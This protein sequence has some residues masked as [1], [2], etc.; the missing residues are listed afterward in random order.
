MKSKEI[1]V[2]RI[3]EVSDTVIF[4]PFKILMHGIDVE[5]I[6]G[7]VTIHTNKRRFIDKLVI[8][9]SFY[10]SA[11]ATAYRQLILSRQPRPEVRISV[12]RVRGQLVPR[13]LN[14]GWSSLGDP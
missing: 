5:L 14:Q 6:N 3:P 1:T 2:F 8:S 11:I 7:L 10:R 4:D 12:R 13:V 9:S